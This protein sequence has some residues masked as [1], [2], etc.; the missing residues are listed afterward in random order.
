MTV[1]ENR[2]LSVFSLATLLVS[3]HYG[4]GFLLGTAEKAVSSGVMGSL[5][6]V[7]VGLGV[8]ASIV[9]AK[10]YWTEIEQIWTLL[11]NRY[12][13]LV[14]IGVGLMSWTSF[15]GIGAVQI[16]AAASILG[17]MGVP[18]LSGM[19][20][21][22]FLFWV[23]SLLEVEKASWLFR[24]FLLLN[25]LGLVYG[26]WVL[27]GLPNYVQ[28]PLQFIS[29]LHQISFAEAIGVSLST[30]LLVLI[31]M[32]CQQYIVQARDVRTVYLGSIF[33]ALAIIA[34]AFLPSAVV[35]AAQ[36]A[37]ILPADLD[38]KAAIP[39]ILSWV[40]GGSNQPLG[41]FLIA[42]LAV[43]SLG[44]GSSVLR[45]QTKTLLDLQLL[46][47]FQGNRILIAGVNALFALGIAL[48]G[49]EIIGLILLFYTAYLSAVWVPWIAYL[50]D[51]VKFYTPSV[52]SVRLSLALGSLSALTTLSIILYQP[53]AVFW[54]NGEL[55]IMIVGIGC[56]SVSLLFGQLAENFNPLSK[57]KEHN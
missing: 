7:S 46:P 50:L 21:V 17:V 38:A 4:L 8:I 47:K 19:L 35:I 10:F 1:D 9:L 43:P 55:T 34:L 6:A 22:T 16:I 26:L 29:S 39:Y 45:V 49:G 27:H 52:F 51:Y 15:I 2:Q 37:A 40:G 12:G 11:G 41:A 36:N 57:L 5:Y 31:D 3:A 20:I 56:G 33:A 44:L 24:G 18:R 48:N 25:I 54:N 23:L 53:N 30:I 28:A 13:N 42:A 32:K 14:K